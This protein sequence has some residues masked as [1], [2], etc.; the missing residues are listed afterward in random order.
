MSRRLTI[1]PTLSEQLHSQEAQAP[2]VSRDKDAAIEGLTALRKESDALVLQ[3]SQWDD[4]RRADERLEHL[5]ALVSQAKTDEREIEELRRVRGRRNVLEGEYAALQ[6]LYKQQETRVA[7]SDRALGTARASLA[8]A[9]Q[10][11][12]EWE[13]RTNENKAAL[14]EARA[15]RDQAENRAAQLEAECTLI[16]VQLDAE[17]RLAKVRVTSCRVTEL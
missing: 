9:E 3:Q 5:A 12:A 4:L 7:S 2:F 6:R 17:E 1:S 13:Q 11:A 15:V 10:R 14:E 8:Q 16:R